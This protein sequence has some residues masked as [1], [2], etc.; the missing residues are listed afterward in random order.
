[1][2]N[3]IKVVYNENIRP[4][5][6]YPSQLCAYLFKRFNMNQGT[7]LLDV[8]CGR[9]DFA[10]GFKD[11]GL[12]VFG[13]DRERSNSEILKG[14]E[15]KT[16]NIEKDSFPFDNGAFDIVFSKSVIEHFWNP[17]HFIQECYRILRPGGTIIIMTP[18]WQSQRCIFYDDFT[19]VHPY[20]SVS[21]KE[22]LQIYNFREV[23]SEI[24][25]QLP[26]LWEH[27][28]LKIF[29]KCLQVFGPVKKIHKNKFF[30]WSRELMILGYGKK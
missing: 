29:S 13:I 4:H 11:L 26:I 15:V 1:M 9:G 30:R 16:I 28:W 18:D 24:F 3:Y 7:K 20:T 21:L 8:G 17:E 23:T 6:K 25:Y 10:K 2:S 14:I 5:T 27:L 19:H 12:D 22:M